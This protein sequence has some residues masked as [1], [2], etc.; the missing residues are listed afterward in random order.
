[1][2]ETRVFVFY[3]QNPMLNIEEFLLIPLDGGLL[4]FL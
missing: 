4:K 1:M 2:I 3:F